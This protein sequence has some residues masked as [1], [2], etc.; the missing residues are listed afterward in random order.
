[1]H[2]NMVNRNL[3]TTTWTQCFCP[4][5]QKS[6][7]NNIPKLNR[8][9]HTYG[10][11]FILS[12]VHEHEM[13]RTGGIWKRLFSISTQFDVLLTVVHI[14][15]FFQITNLMHTSFILLQYI[16]Y[17]IVLDMFRAALCSSSGGQIVSLQHL[18]SSLSVNGRTVCRLRADCS[19][20]STGIQ[21]VCRCNY[22]TP[23]DCQFLYKL[24]WNHN[25]LFS[26]ASISHN[27]YSFL[28]IPK[29]AHISNT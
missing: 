11:N 16:C 5:T 14:I 10:F 19:P 24:Q 20:L 7:N 6:F 17:I 22:C 27:Y 15:D 9:W 28:L 8:S 18:V 25:P 21:G 23:Y 26:Y 3:S 13:V 4:T 12:K 1:M 29:T 2:L